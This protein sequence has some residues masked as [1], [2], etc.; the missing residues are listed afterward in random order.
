M[1]IKIFNSYNLF[2]N[3]FKSILKLSKILYPPLQKNNIKK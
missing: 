1:F 2:F 3:D